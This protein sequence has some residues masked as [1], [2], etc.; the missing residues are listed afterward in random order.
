M[1]TNGDTVALEKFLRPMARGLSTEL[2]LAIVNLTADEETQTRYDA[3]AEKRTEGQLT[4]AELEE[5][6]SFV[7][8]NTLLAILKTEA[9]AVL[10]KAA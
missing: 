7:R 8:I 9:Q 6:E 3:L 5:L 2:A 10:A 1:K 4:P